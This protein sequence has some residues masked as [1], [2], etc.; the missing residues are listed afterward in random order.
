MSE[1]YGATR[2]NYVHIAD[3][4]GLHAA[5]VD[6]PVRVQWHAEIADAARFLGDE[7]DGAWPGPEFETVDGQ[8]RPFSP[9]THICPFMEAGD[10]LVIVSSGSTDDDNVVSGWAE[11]WHSN[12]GCVSLQLDEIYQ[13]AAQAFA[14]DVESVTVAEYDACKPRQVERQRG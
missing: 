4:A 5:L 6:V 7:D 13:R 3:R 10:V 14:I 1:W 11:A 8:C 12:G 2:T 9:A